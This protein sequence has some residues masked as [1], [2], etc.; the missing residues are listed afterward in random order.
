MTR[1][2][3]LRR[4]LFGGLL[5]A[6]GA[7]GLYLRK[8]ALW[9]VPREPLHVF[10]AQQ[11]GIY[12]AIAARV[13]RVD[14][15][16]PVRI[17]HEVDRVLSSAPL[18]AQNDLRRLLLLF[19]NGL[20]GLVLDGRMQPFTRLKGDEQDRALDQWRD[21]RLVLRRGG[22]HALRKLALAAH[23]GSPQTWASVGYP[24]PPD[25]SGAVVPR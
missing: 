4:G 5:L 3:F 6:A 20:T 1:R 25:I 7:T 8:S 15:A 10:D 19:E 17:A 22:Y 21:S 24:G 14:G 12:A 18:E 16:D 13:V 23:Y 2:R 11:F 9:F